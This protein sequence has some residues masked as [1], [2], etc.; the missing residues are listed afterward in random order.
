MN[1]DVPLIKKAKKILEDILSNDFNAVT[2]SNVL[3]DEQLWHS[4]SFWDSLSPESSR[5][6]AQLYQNIIKEHEKH[7]AHVKAVKTSSRSAPSSSPV[8]SASTNSAASSSSSATAE[9]ADATS[10]SQGASAP[11][12]R[13]KRAAQ[14]G[15][16]KPSNHEITETCEQ[17]SSFKAKSTR[18]KK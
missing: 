13:G 10:S 8:S 1:Y 18:G 9:N 7:K 5:N 12:T 4:E 6:Y 3:K 2:I 16:S 11:Q 17:K 14:L 15:D